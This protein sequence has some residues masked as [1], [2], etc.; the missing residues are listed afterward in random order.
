MRQLQEF[1][2]SVNTEEA[3]PKPV[4]IIS[5]QGISEDSP[6]CSKVVSTA[7]DYFCTFDLDALYIVT[8]PSDNHL[9]KYI[10]KRMIPIAKD[11]CHVILPYEHFGTHYDG[12]NDTIDEELETLNY[13]K[14]G[15]VISE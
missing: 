13:E 6:R 9:D 5:I 11:L 4:A 14:A 12:N 3:L 15:K 1:Q 2:S 8:T 7:I 10:H